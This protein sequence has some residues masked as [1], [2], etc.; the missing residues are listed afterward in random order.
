MKINRTRVLRGISFL[1]VIAISIWIYSIKDQA[2]QLAAYGYPGIFIVA[3][4]ANATVFLPAPGVAVVF[5][6]GS[7]FSPLLVALFAGTG[8]AIGELV[9]YLAGY[10]GQGIVENT[11]MFAR[12]EPWVRRYGVFAIFILAALPNPFFDIAGV[13]AGILKIPI[14]KFF[15]ACWL[16]QLIKMFAFAYAGSVSISWLGQWLK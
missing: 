4:L 11:Q 12:I 3:M 8:A 7:I 14:G 13:A 2:A 16:G 10:S 15:I 9:G 5:A 6:M 1:A